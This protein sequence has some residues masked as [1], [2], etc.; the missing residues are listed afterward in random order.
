[1]IWGGAGVIVIEMRHTI[2]AMHLNHPETVPPP[3]SMEKLSS[4]KLL[5]GV[6]KKKKKWL[7]ATV[8]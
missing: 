4:M 5:L 3:Q 8:V 6:K 1:M 7:G 2:D